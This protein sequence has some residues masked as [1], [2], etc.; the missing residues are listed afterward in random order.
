MHLFERCAALLLA[1]LDARESGD[2]LGAAALRAERDA[3]QHAWE[4]LGAPATTSAAP[5]GDFAL[6]L[7]AASTELAHREAVDTALRERL[8]ALGAAAA[9]AMPAT[10]RSRAALPRGRQPG[11]RAFNDPPPGTHLL[12]VTF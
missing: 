6:T 7:E 10:A 5:G 12:D 2:R 9:R 1:E 3:L 8:A 4:E 11:A